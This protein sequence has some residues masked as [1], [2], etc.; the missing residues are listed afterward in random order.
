[1]ASLVLS[2]VESGLDEY[3]GDDLKKEKKEKRKKKGEE[4]K[5]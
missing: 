3:F 5:E 2:E 4:K 1:M